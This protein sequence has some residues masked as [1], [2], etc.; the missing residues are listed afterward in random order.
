MVESRGFL[1]V[2]PLEGHAGDVGAQ[3]ELREPARRRGRDDAQV[4]L[5]AVVGA[6]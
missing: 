6:F 3:D 4:I 5:V 2:D 1:V